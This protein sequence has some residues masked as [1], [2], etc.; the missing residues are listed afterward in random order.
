MLH[1][2]KAL[3]GFPI[4]AVDGELGRVKDIYFDDATWTI[5]FL[6]VDTGGWLTGRRV[7]ISPISIAA[8]NW[9]HKAVDVKLT[10][11]QVHDSPGI[12]SAKP[13]SR[14]HETALYNYYG[15]PYY[16]SGPYIW[17]Y[18]VFPVLV[19]QTP[20]EDPE[21]QAIR[22]QLEGDTSEEDPHLRSKDEVIGYDIEATDETVGHV[23]DFLF[24]EKDWSI[25]LMVIDTRNWWPG[26]HVL[27]S[28]KR[29]E[30]VS[31]E[32]KTVV[33]NVTREQIEHS[34]EYD[35]HHPPEPEAVEEVYR[36]SSGPMRPGGARKSMPRPGSRR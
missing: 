22:A 28:P 7:L 31:W 35:A 18:T 36:H 13:V 29:I 2:V 16:W 25:P 19:E 33:V 4:A 6:E 1:S 10:R 14:Q 15:Y 20:F 23:D 32:E 3:D 34:P 21:S 8:I 24:D 17:G 30:R 11:Q 9:S 5:R 26:K 27:I 12:D